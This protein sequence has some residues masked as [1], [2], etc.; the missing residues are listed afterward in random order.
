MGPRAFEA[1][2]AENN[3]RPVGIS[4]LGPRSQTG[5]TRCVTTLVVLDNSR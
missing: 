1:E 3:H 4:S 2:T 5:A